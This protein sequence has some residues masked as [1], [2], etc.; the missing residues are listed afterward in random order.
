MGKRKA[1]R[2]CAA[3]LGMTLLFTGVAGCKQTDGE[4]QT[5]GDVQKTGGSGSSVFDGTL[6]ENVTIRVLEND[7][8]ISKGYFK[9]L[10]EAFNEAYADYGIVAVDANMDQ[11][12]D[13]ANDGPYGYGPD[14]LY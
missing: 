11:Y 6:E 14:V 8:A 13:L 9:N 5:S 4:T 12:L 1:K 7:T 3:V 10:I 2:A